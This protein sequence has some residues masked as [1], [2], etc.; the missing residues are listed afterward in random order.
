MKGVISRA[1]IV[2]LNRS[3]KECELEATD[4]LP[5]RVHSKSYYSTIMYPHYFKIRKK[6]NA[7]I[8]SVGP[9]DTEN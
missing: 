3:L 6:N 8:E 5:T 9:R 7:N 1:V 4:D 2:Y